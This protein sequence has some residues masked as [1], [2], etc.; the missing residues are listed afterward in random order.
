[1]N[2]KALKTGKLVLS[3]LFVADKTEMGGA[4]DMT[5]TFKVSIILKKF[6]RYIEKQ[7]YFCK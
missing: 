7:Y 3:F 1:M 4:D 5:Y 6:I 2:F